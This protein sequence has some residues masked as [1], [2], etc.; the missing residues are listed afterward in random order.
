MLV[1]EIQPEESSGKESSNPWPLNAK[2]PLTLCGSPPERSPQRAAYAPPRR[3][4]RSVP[5]LSI[6]QVLLASS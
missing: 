5:A 6:V 1:V 4:A 3:P 2:V